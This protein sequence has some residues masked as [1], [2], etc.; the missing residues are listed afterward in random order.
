MIP[1]AV[2]GRCRWVTMPAI[3]TR[4]PSSVFARSLAVSTPIC[5]RVALEN[6]V[7]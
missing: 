4:V 3:S 5:R 1:E 6:S 2:A 7:G